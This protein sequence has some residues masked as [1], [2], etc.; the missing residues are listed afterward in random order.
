MFVKS[1][2]VEGQK[3]KPSVLIKIE[4]LIN[5]AVLGSEAH[6]KDNRMIMMS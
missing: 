1:N 5:T 4:T 3:L 2:Q 6:V